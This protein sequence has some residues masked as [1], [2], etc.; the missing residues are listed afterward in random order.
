[1]ENHINNMMQC[2]LLATQGAGYVSPNPLVGAM[3]VHDGNMIGAGYHQQYGTAHAEVNCL[4]SVSTENKHLIAE[5]T[6]YVNLEPCNHHG[7][8]PPC[9]DA[10]LA[11]GIKKVI[12]GSKDVNEKVNGTGIQKLKENGVEVIENVL[13]QQCLA[14]NRRFFTYQSKKRPYIILK[15]AESQDGF[16]AVESKERTYLT[17]EKASKTNHQW[18][19]QEDAILVGFQTALNDNPQLNVRHAEGRDPVRILWDPKLEL[20]ASHAIMDGK[21]PTIVMN[22]SKEGLENNIRFVKLKSIEE[23]VFFLYENK[24][25]SIII[26]G[27]PKTI[28]KFLDANLWDEARIIKSEILLENGYRANQL[29]NEVYMYSDKQ[30]T[31]EIFY[32]KNNQNL[33][34]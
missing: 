18:R 22:D 21:Q 27:G 32:F 11:A 10:I 2:L 4:A 30:G 8:T 14:V 17:G 23:L 16:V 7:N 19:T 6:M 28:Q 3:L 31:D 15:W 33:Y 12:V 5:S 34:L 13:E 29:Q 20:P 24:T 25:L 9:T 1:M 26:E